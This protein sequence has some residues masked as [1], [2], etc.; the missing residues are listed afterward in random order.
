AVPAHQA[1]PGPA[2]ASIDLAA[3]DRD[4]DLGGAVVAGHELHLQL[5]HLAQYDREHVAV[6]AGTGGADDERLR[7]HVLP[8]LDAGARPEGANADLVRYAAQPV[9]LRGLVLRA[10]AAAEQGIEE[11]AA[12]EAAEAQAVLRGDAVEVVRRLDAAGAGHVLHH[13]RW[14]ARNVLRDVAGE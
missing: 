6:G 7:P 9:V 13:D 3:L 4:H 8:G 2:A 12:R 14:V 10:F 11:G 5:E 1:R